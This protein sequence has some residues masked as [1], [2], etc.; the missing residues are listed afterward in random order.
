[1]GTPIDDICAAENKWEILISKPGRYAFKNKKGGK[2][3]FDTNFKKLNGTG[4]YV[5]FHRI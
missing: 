3:P 1:M 5:V 2:K 4:Y